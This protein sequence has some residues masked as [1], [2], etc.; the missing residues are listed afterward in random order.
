MEGNMEVNR[1][2]ILSFLA[3]EL[4]KSEPKVELVKDYMAKVGLDYSEDPVERI[5]IVL[6]ALH[7]EEPRKIIKK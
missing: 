1:E 5:N 7:F 3:E 2:E 6:Q 4:I